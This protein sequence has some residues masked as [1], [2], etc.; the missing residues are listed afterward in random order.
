MCDTIKSAQADSIPKDNKFQWLVFT[1]TNRIFSLSL[2][3]A[4]ITDS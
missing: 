2:N 4:I 1:K 3:F